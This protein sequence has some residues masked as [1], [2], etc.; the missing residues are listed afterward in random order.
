MVKCNKCG[1][2]YPS[3]EGFFYKRGERFSSPCK[4]CAIARSARRYAE[5]HEQIN[6]ALRAAMALPENRERKRIQDAK[7]YRKHREKR[8]KS[9]AEYLARPE[10]Q[11]RT[12][13]Y[14]K[15]LRN[16]PGFVEEKQQYLRQYHIESRKDPEKVLE[17]RR[18]SNAHW[19]ANPEKYR[20]HVRNRRARLRNAPGTHTAS[21]VLRLLE[22]QGFRCHWC[23]GDISGGKHTVDHYIPL[24]KGGSNGPENLVMACLTCNCSKSDKLPDEFKTYLAQ[25][26]SQ[27]SG[28][29][30]WQNE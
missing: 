22:D 9:Q 6:A 27:T 15:S 4:A 2:E 14:F 24:A 18:K 7:S 5:K 13:E 25:V 8:R 21:D 10:V 1:T 16:R 28:E 26:A 20:A 12:R 3:K 30:S 23:G 29:S 11:A 19:K 17:L